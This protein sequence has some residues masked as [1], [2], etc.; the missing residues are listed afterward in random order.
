MNT[1]GS[2][3]HPAQPCH[4]PNLNTQSVTAS[5]QWTTTE[6]TK[7]LPGPSREIER[8]AL[9]QA[10]E[11]G[12]LA[13]RQIEPAEVASCFND[14]G[15]PGSYTLALQGMQH[16]SP[17]GQWTVGIVDPDCLYVYKQDPGE[18][19]LKQGAEADKLDVK[20]LSDLQSLAEKDK[21]VQEQA[22]WEVYKRFTSGHLGADGRF[23]LP[24]LKP[25]KYDSHKA[26]SVYS[27]G[28]VPC[29]QLVV[30][31]NGK[32]DIK[33]FFVMSNVRGNISDILQKK[34][35]CEQALSLPPLPLVVFCPDT[36]SAEV[37]YD[38][39]LDSEHLTLIEPCLDF[40]PSR[41]SLSKIMDIMKLLPMHLQAEA[42]RS[43]FSIPPDD[44]HKWQQA[45]ELV[46]NPCPNSRQKLLE[47]QESGLH[48]HRCFFHE[49][50]MTSLLDLLLIS[51]IDR[52]N[53]HDRVTE[54]RADEVAPLLRLLLKN[55]AILTAWGWRHFR[56]MGIYSQLFM[57][58]DM[59]NYMVAAF[60]PFK[61]LTLENLWN[62][63]LTGCPGGIVEFDRICQE[64]ND[65]QRQSCLKEGLS[66]KR[67]YQKK[68]TLDTLEPFL[69]ALFHF[70][71]VLDEDVLDAV[72]SNLKRY[73]GETLIDNLSVA[74]YIEWIKTLWHE[75]NTHPLF[76][77]W[78][79]HVEKANQQLKALKDSLDLPVDRL[80]SLTPALQLMVDAFSKPPVLPDNVGDNED[81]ILKVLQHYYRR[82]GPE[83]VVASLN[84]IFLK[85]WKNNHSC[86]HA[87][88]AR[89][90]GL[91]YMELLERCQVHCFNPVEKSL[92]PLA[93][94]YQN[95]AAED[96]DKSEVKTRSAVY[97]KRDLTGHF[98]EKLLDEV[99]LAMVN[100]KNDIDGI[101][102]QKLSETVRWY[103]RILR[104]ADRMEFIRNIVEPEFPGLATQ[105]EFF[106]P[107]YL[108]LPDQWARHFTSKPDHKTEFQRHLEAAMHGAAD[109]VQVT[110]TNPV[111]QRKN[112]YAKVYGLMPDGKKIT[113]QFDRTAE[114][115]QG[116]DRF[117]DDN[118]RRKIAKKAG[119][120]TC[121]DPSHKT[122]KAD[123][124]KGITYG[125]HNSW[126]DL[127]QVRIPAAMTLLEKMQFEHDPSLLSPATQQAIE[128]EVQRLKSEGIRMNTGT[129]TQETLDSEEA[130]KVLEDRGIA[131]VSEKRH[132]FAADGFPKERE[133]LVPKKM[134][135]P[136]AQTA[137]AEDSRQNPLISL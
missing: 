13:I 4:Q 51:E 131:V 120:I 108:D 118:V 102:V 73:D 87:L 81:T 119:I 31:N 126:Y 32:A 48:I 100:M 77:N 89:N 75:R 127:R 39:E 36:G 110:T 97:F 26:G 25:G 58:P 37:C 40:D 95:A 76:R 16:G 135:K 60:G 34:R 68:T 128:E 84:K 44:Q 14:N 106:N 57:P 125:I 129:L 136:D 109:L 78:P 9:R 33:C 65:Q 66:F 72:R 105:P 24:K 121:S 23:S 55:G 35:E 99:A 134:E 3:Q 103:L 130:Q 10:A 22:G 124:N 56:R 122:C 92:L 107:S 96:V 1:F 94:I 79:A 50:K 112:P 54:F 18:W 70:G 62:I 19:P 67:L 59:F 111:D 82:P 53:A 5:G 104:F 11:S 20:L 2:I 115:V 93:I 86:N 28:S 85:P 43:G 63:P 117:I 69:I 91:W 113:L 6:P 132:Y 45:I 38:D 90:N 74:G 21:E 137:P 116:M 114:P 8:Q 41:K 80:A 101:A 88:R 123:Q 30:T 64:Y 61:F 42:L 52:Y 12:R 15:T 98:P 83:R 29:P 7:Q 133:M 27:S 71:A 46:S 17:R 47:L 49:G